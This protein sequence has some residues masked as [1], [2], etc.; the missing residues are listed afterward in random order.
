MS[1]L[2]VGTIIEKVADAG[3]A[4]DGVTLKDG[5]VGTA[6]SPVSLQASSLNGGQF[7]GRRNLIING[8]MQLSQRVGDSS[9]SANNYGA[10]PDRIRQEA[11]GGASA[12]FQRVT[13]AP[14]G[15]KHSLKVTCA[16]TTAPTS[17]NT[18]RLMTGLEGQ[19]V[20]HLSYGTAQA[21]KATLSFYV[22]ASET[23]TYSVAFVNIAPS[24]DITSNVTR[25]F[26]KTYT[27]NSSNTWEYKTLTFDGCPDGTWGS[28]NSDGITII[29]DLGSGSDHQGTTDTWL[30][31]SDTSASGQVTLGDS[32]GGTWQITGIQLEVG[33][34]ATPFEHRSFG[35]ELELCKRYF[36]KTNPNDANTRGELSGNLYTS[37][38]AVVDHVLQPQ[39]RAS[40]T[41]TR[42]GTNDNFY[43]AGKDTNATGTTSTT[44]VGPTSIWIEIGSMTIAN[45]GAVGLNCTYNG[46]LSIDAEL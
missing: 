37:N 33:E 13:D 23:G 1:T 38:Q 17:G 43:V 12:S 24:G 35:E 8:A 2:T 42:G 25:S 28:S 9:S 3:V 34:Q 7:G 4:V 21:K 5:G 39:M 6:S 15:F 45:S 41:I 27:V 10:T 36:Y 31:T 30:T 19:N 18:L 44:F 22:K 26:I 11:Y 40:P 14:T 46:Q 16:G 29:F 20:A 32:N